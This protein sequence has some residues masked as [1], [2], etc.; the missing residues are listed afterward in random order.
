MGFV[1]RTLSKTE[2]ETMRK[3]NR[4]LYRD[5]KDLLSY[6]EEMLEQD[7]QKTFFESNGKGGYTASGNPYVVAGRQSFDKVQEI[8]FG[9]CA[10]PM[11]IRIKAIHATNGN[12]SLVQLKLWGNY[13]YDSSVLLFFQGA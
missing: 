8:S 7:I 1:P 5:N 13:G 3:F 9:Y 12:P 2:I 10:Q 11:Y 4:I 6:Q